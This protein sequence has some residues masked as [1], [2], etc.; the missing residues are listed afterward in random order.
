MNTYRAI[1]RLLRPGI[2]YSII[3]TVIPGLL[4]GAELPSAVL[5]FNALLGTF[6][7]V[8]ASSCYNQ[9]LERHSDA[10]M[11]RTKNRILPLGILDYQTVIMIGSSLLGIGLLILLLFVNFLT[12]ALGFFSFVFYVVVYTV[13]LKPNTESN[14]VLGGVSGAIGPLMGEA[15]VT[16]T[17]SYEGW[18]LYALLFFW[19]PAHFWAL[20]IYLKE[21]YAKAGLPMLPVVRGATYTVRL[22]I[23]YQLLLV[24]A[25]V[26]FTYFAGMA[27]AVFLVPTTL[28]GVWVLYKM[29]ALL[30][31]PDP[32]A[33]RRVFFMTILH[34]VVWHLAF[35]LDV[36]VSRGPGFWG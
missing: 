11:E 10:K 13:L 16:G 27:G 9:V 35:C 14:T 29:F 36:L 34:N 5:V 26:V 32:L 8:L 6:L 7:L 21:D 12:A 33:S 18:V 17:L 25:A 19:Q 24:V 15:A 1:Y 31:D 22:M 28:V 30:K 2:G 20:A 3:I 23:A 4:L